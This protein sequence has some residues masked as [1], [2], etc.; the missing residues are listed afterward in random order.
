MLDDAPDPRPT[1]V[2]SEAAK[3]LLH[4][5]S[6]TD[7]GSSRSRSATPARSLK[8]PIAKPANKAAGNVIA[9]L[10]RVLQDEGK[11]AEIAQANRLALATRKAELKAI[12]EQKK[13][14]A[15]TT[16]HQNRMAHDVRMKEL[17]LE[18]M[19]LEVELARMKSDATAPPLQ[20]SQRIPPIFS[21]SQPPFELQS[22]TTTALQSQGM[23]SSIFSPSQP[24]FESHQPH[25]W[26]H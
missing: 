26:P 6:T 21:P 8:K 25:Q 22:N 24:P 17:E 4:R 23:P 14:D 12:A 1:P 11:A 2:G 5:A 20:Q 18:K 19:K 7:S 15:R 9:E 3:T 10:G 13:E 16:R